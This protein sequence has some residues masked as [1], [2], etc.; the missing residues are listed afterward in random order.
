M[1][2]LETRVFEGRNVW[3]HTPVLQ[4]RLRLEPRE[5]LPT[6]EIPGFTERLLDLLPALAEH[7]CGRGYAGGFLERLREGTY[8]GHVVE[9]VALELQAE[10]GFQVRYGKTVRG[11]SL[12]TWDVVLEYGTPALGEAALQ[13]AVALV[14]AVLE[15]RAFPVPETLARLRELGA[16]TCLG[17]STK[18]ILEACRARGIPVLSLSSGSLFQ[19]G[20]GCRQKLV[21]ATITSQTGALA[22]DLA[23][24][25]VLTK[26]LLAEA[27][28]PVPRGR[29]VSS[30]QD[31]QAAVREMGGP[32]VLKPRHG[33]QGKGVILNLNDP[34]EVETAF[35]I[36][37]NYDS[38]LLVEEYIAG[39]HYR[40]LVIGEKLVA[41]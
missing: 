39:R 37:Q 35:R 27:G 10:A 12:E 31:A 33:N 41:A 26:N 17:P 19:L 16:E 24:D 25:K 38:Q 3:S 6:C 29:V 2:I 7:A 18:S 32:V 20:Y 23:C 9:H 28:L 13:A 30:I 1:E 36:A 8:L 21:R 5:Q 40:L 22:V 14:T 34:R 15:E 4:A 11:F